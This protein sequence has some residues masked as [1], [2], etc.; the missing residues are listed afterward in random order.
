MKA[1]KSEWGYMGSRGCHGEDRVHFG[2]DF[3]KNHG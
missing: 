3:E 2:F 1:L